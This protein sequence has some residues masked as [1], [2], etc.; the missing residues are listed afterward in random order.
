[1]N[2]IVAMAALSC[3]VSI[4]AM[5]PRNGAF[6]DAGWLPCGVTGVE[7]RSLTVATCGSGVWTT[8]L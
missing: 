2:G 7:Y 4:R 5:L 6:A 3:E 1:L 8:T